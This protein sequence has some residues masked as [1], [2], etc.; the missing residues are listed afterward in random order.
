M[1]I[2]YMVI[3]ADTAISNFFLSVTEITLMSKPRLIKIRNLQHFGRL[4]NLIDWNKLI[5]K[6]WKLRLIENIVVV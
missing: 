6:M 2:N 5:L 1:L 4:R 3:L